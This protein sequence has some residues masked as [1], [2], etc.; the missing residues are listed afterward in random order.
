M[1]ISYVNVVCPHCNHKHE[2]GYPYVGGARDFER[3]LDCGVC[4]KKM[5]IE[6]K[7]P[8]SKPVIEIYKIV[9]DN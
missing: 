1:E 5:Y 8:V 4:H 7:Y 6:V 3:V 2:V 9:K